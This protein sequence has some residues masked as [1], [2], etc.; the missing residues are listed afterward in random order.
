MGQKTRPSPREGLVQYGVHTT[1]EIRH[2]YHLGGLPAHFRR[3]DWKAV[4]R[5]RTDD[6]LITSEPLY[7]LSYNGKHWQKYTEISA[8][9]QIKSAHRVHPMMRGSIA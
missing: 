8:K 1:P 3:N 9:E 2:L 4:D 6:L 7:Q 5:T